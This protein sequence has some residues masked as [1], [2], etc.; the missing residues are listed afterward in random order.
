MPSQCKELFGLWSFIWKARIF[1][2]VEQAPK[3]LNGLWIINYIVTM[4]LFYQFHDLLVP[5]L[6][7]H[8]FCNCWSVV[9]P[10]FNFNFLPY[11]PLIRLNVRLQKQLV[12]LRTSWYWYHW[13]KSL[14]SYNWS[15]YR[16]ITSNITRTFWIYQELVGIHRRYQGP[17]RILLLHIYTFKRHILSKRQLK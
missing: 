10:F 9:V 11:I 2:Y 7:W 5:G 12:G 8:A 13:L 15:N 16:N 14:S 17:D 3:V 6:I 4:K 1:C